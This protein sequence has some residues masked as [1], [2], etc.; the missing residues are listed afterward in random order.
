[1]GPDG[2]VDKSPGRDLPGGEKIARTI[3]AM[4]ERTRA[5]AQSGA[6]SVAGRGSL[7]GHEPNTMT[8]ER[9][10]V[11]PGGS[12]QRDVKRPS[13]ECVGAA[14]RRGLRELAEIKEK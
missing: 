8:V 5:L 11:S 4:F 7:A 10:R 3:L 2:G 13:G 1:M 6:K 14:R 12:H 9:C